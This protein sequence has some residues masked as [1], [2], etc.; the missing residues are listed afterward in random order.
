MFLDVDG[1]GILTAADVVS[2]TGPTTLE[3]WLRTD[4]NRNG[5]PAS[6]VTQDGELT[7]SH[8]EFVLHASNGTLSWIGFV[9]RQAMSVNLGEGS[10]PTDYHNGY[11]GGILPPGTYHLASVTVDVA[12]GTPSISAYECI[13]ERAPPSRIAISN[14]ISSTS[15]ISRAPACTGAKLR[16][17]REAE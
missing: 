12:T 13:T 1:D 16:P 3:V 10:S 9:N 8:Y 15:A 11:G 2:P 5:S 4:T 7:F 17:A 6:C 14:G